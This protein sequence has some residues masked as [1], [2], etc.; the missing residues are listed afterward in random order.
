MLR[1]DVKQDLVD[2]DFQATDRKSVGYRFEELLRHVTLM[3]EITRFKVYN[4]K[5]VVIWSD[6]KRLVGQSFADNEE[7]A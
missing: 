3:P 4:P 6:D 1:A 5:G 2:Y 7:F